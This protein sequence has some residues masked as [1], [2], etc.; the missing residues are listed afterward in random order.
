MCLFLLSCFYLLPLG[1]PQITTRD[2]VFHFANEWQ[3]ER[4][5]AEFGQLLR[6]SEI[7]VTHQN[8]FMGELQSRFQVEKLI[9]RVAEKLDSAEKAF[10]VDWFNSIAGRRYF[11]FSLNKDEAHYLKTLASLAPERKLVL[12]QTAEALLWSW[13]Q[14]ETLQKLRLQMGQLWKY[15]PLSPRE[16][17]QEMK[18][19]RAWYGSGKGKTSREGLTY[20]AFKTK[21]FSDEDLLS[22]ATFLST[23][24]VEK[25]RCVFARELWSYFEE[26]FTTSLALVFPEKEFP[27]VVTAG[28]E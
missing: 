4:I 28:V 11:G 7:G 27:S 12:A 22:L 14:V 20:L 6:R 18:T 3:L 19:F 10:L 26:A 25:L 17:Q 9:Y 2:V 23:K 16:L 24:Q 5:Q 8:K 1:Q 13:C 15:E 21:G